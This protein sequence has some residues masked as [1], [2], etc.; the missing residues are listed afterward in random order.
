MTPTSVR[1]GGGRAGIVRAAVLE[2]VG[3]PAVIAELRLAAPG[4]GEVRVRMLASGVCHSDLHVRDGEW[5]RPT[6]IVMGH[7][8]AG[9][10]DAV[11]PG[12]GSPRVGQLVALSWLV[13]CGVCRACR[14]GQVW[15]CPDSPSFRHRMLDGRTVFSRGAGGAG[16][17]GS[18]GRLA[19]DQ[20]LSYCAIATMAE[21]SVVPAAA[22]IP[23]PDGTDP[24]AA[25]LIGCCVTTGVGAVLK[26]AQVPAG[27]SV[28]VIGL[29]GVGL[30]CVMGAVV[31]GASGIVAVDR[32]PAKLA[33]AREVGATD[34]IEAGDDPAR[35]AEALRDLTDGGPDFVF[36]AIGRTDTVELAIAALPLGGTAVLVGMTPLGQ[37]AAFEVYPLVDGSRRILGSN[38]GFA[39]P[40]IDFPR[41][42]AWTL[43]G[44]LPVDRLIDRRIGLD[45]LEDAFAAMRRGE[46]T[47]QVID[48]DLG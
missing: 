36:E 25:A 21:A 43:D 11:G 9:I 28:A 2:S 5:D 20:I 45:D 17:A 33:V 12:V 41:Y 34:T 22:A 6:P 13:P 48:F 23:V 37:R 32:V 7:E 24:A 40:A 30:S 47:R 26:T 1:A 42:A 35:T 15:A 27:S 39:E 31:A 3:S 29:G 14:R 38:Y 44:R 19:A 18:A 4:P 46:Y 16:R 8:G 10:V